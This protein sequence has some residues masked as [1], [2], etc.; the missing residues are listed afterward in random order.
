MK[1]APSEVL[2][3]DDC[4]IDAYATDRVLFLSSKP[5]VYANINYN[6]LSTTISCRQTSIVRS[7]LQTGI[8]MDLKVRVGDWFWYCKMEIHIVANLT[9]IAMSSLEAVSLS[10]VA[11][12]HKDVS[13][14]QVASTLKCELLRFL[15]NPQLKCK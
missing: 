6:A 3:V 15:I 10:K 9:C 4:G 11:S 12:L 14:T 7:L 13:L 8:K 1:F 2:S 5:S